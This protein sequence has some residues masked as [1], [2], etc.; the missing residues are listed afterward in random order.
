LLLEEIMNGYSFEDSILAIATSLTPQALSILRGSGRDCINILAKVFSHPDVLLNSKGNETHV[1]WIVD[2]KTKFDQVVVS[3]YKA[4]K[5]F[6]GEDSVEITC[7]GSP[8]VTISIYNLLIKSGFRQAEKGEF[9]FRSFFNGK[10]N[11]TQAEA[12]KQLTSSKT[13]HE[14]RL[15]LSS[16]SNKLFYRVDEIKNE[17]LS[18]FATVDVALEYPEEEID[19]DKKTFF[20]KLDKIIESISTLLEKWKID[21]LFIEGAKVVI[22]GRA[23][24]GKSSLFN[25]LLNEERSIVSDIEGTTRDYIDSDLSFKGVPIT[26]YDTAGIRHTKD[27]I[28]KVGLERSFKI[29]EE[30]TLV[31][32]LIYGL[33]TPEDVSFLSTLKKPCIVLLTKI[34]IA[35]PLSEVYKA[36]KELN[37]KNIISISSKTHVG[38]EEL[39]ETAY[40]QLCQKNE[41]VEDEQS[42]IISS[43]QKDL[44]T[45]TIECLNNIRDN[46]N[47]S[48]LDIIMQELQEAL[49]ALGEIT[50]EVR[51]DDILDSIFSQFCV[52]K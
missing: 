34:D 31:L 7:H 13:E 22:A 23:N 48:Y 51:S 44:L 33:L 52:G 43:R 9:S 5:S 6:T 27:V 10:I 3:V 12:I 14:V 4:P 41:S 24:A 28:E 46:E 20:E 30:A 19:F 35:S 45:K 47:F 15:A 49:N 37:I 25:V 39:I 26:L 50:G 11:L 40:K 36:L 32:Y 42:A 38:I 8:Y 18:L 21:K 1:G 29:I 17:V 16:L 2:E